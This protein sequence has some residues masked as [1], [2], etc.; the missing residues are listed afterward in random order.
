MSHFYR[1]KLDQTVMHDLKF[2]SKGR[3]INDQPPDG[4]HFMQSAYGPPR[5][6]RIVVP[7]SV[8]PIRVGEDVIQCYSHRLFILSSRTGKS[9]QREDVGKESSSFRRTE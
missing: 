8:C 4:M 2:P 9:L 1:V 7:A 6:P 3:S 5:I